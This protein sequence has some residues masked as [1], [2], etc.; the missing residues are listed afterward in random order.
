MFDLGIENTTIVRNGSAEVGNVYVDAGRIAAVGTDS[1]PARDRVDGS[2]RALLPG[3]VDTH[4]HLMDPGETERED[5]PSGTAAAA[6]SGVTTVLEHTHANPVRTVADLERKRAHL[7]GRSWVD[8]GLVAHAWPGASAEAEPLWRAG[9][10]Y[11]KLFTCETHGVAAHDAVSV[12]EHFTAYAELGARALVHCEDDGLTAAA[13]QALRAAGRS[14]GAVVAEWRSSLAE[15]VAVAEVVQIARRTGARVGIAHCSS[16]TIVGLVT[17]ARRAG[18]DVVAEAC[19]QYMLLREGELA[20]LGPLR[21]FT[22]PARARDDADESAMWG[23][24]REGELAFVSSDH[25]PSSRAQKDRDIWEAPFGLP[26]LDTTS[27]LLLD[28]VGRGALTLP[29]LARVYS[30]GPA[31]HYGLWPRKGSLEIGTDAD[32]V[33]VDPRAERVLSEGDLRSKAGWTPYLGRRVSGRIDAAW[34]W[35]ELL[36][37]DGELCGERRGRFQ[38]GPGCF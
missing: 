3:F 17:E 35:G 34:L 21:K 31:R 5:F 11:F 29:D 15:E 13:E 8:Y 25:A 9:I 7:Q 26:G 18:A 19:P 2:G 1:H 24:L 28:A 36:F 27:S 32:L 10:A 4:V 37:R 6:G 30:E 12:L 22:P 16:P 38:P 23:L 14:D 33:L 20:E